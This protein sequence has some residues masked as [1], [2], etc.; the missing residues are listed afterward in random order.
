MNGQELQTLEAIS[1]VCGGFLKGYAIGNKLLHSD[2]NHY[3]I[4]DEIVNDAYLTYETE[5]VP[6]K[7]GRMNFYLIDKLS[8]SS[9]YL[10]ISKIL[11]VT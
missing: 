5:F 9:E 4:T 11:K 2:E 3:K 10:Y 6:F 1:G 7:E 8:K